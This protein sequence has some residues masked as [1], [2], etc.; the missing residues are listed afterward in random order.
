MNALAEWGE[1]LKCPNGDR[2]GETLRLQDWQRTLLYAVEDDA[3]GSIGCSTGKGPGKTT[4]PAA[5]ACAYLSPTGPAY[6]EGN[7][8]IVVAG[9]LTLTKPFLGQLPGFLNQL[10]PDQ[11]SLTGS[12]KLGGEFRVRRAGNVFDTLAYIPGRCQLH[13]LS[14]NPAQLHGHQPVIV[15]GDEAAHWN[16]R[17]SEDAL[18]LA[19]SVFTPENARSPWLCGS[20]PLS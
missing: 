6:R 16:A 8:I 10:H 19:I 9:S 1:T 20:K 2:Q 13:V 17:K 4:L 15:V 7:E 3:V 14:G 11:P 5:L 12:R 18:N